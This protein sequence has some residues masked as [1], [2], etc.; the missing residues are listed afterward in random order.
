MAVWFMCPAPFPPPQ[1]GGG[2]EGVHSFTVGASPYA[3]LCRPF[4]ALWYA[5]TIRDIRGGLGGYAITIWDIRG[6]CGY[7][8]TKGNLNKYRKYVI[9]P[10]VSNA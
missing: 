10:Y 8:I 1:R 9:L 4:G 6:A 3:V 7:A 5:I 2:V